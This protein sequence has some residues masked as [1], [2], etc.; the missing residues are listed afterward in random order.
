MTIIFDAEELYTTLKIEAV[1]ARR[2][3][4]DLVAEALALLFEA[5][6]DEREAIGRRARRR[7]DKRGVE[8]VLEELGLGR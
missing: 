8:R 6:R 4:K 3:A 7:D 1:R 5:T 2:P